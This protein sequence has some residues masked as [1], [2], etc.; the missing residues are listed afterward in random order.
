[1]MIPNGAARINV[2]TPSRRQANRCRTCSRLFIN[3]DLAIVG[4]GLQHRTTKDDCLR[5]LLVLSA[6]EGRHQ[7][8]EAPYCGEE[9]IS[10]VIPPPG[11]DAAEPQ[12]VDVHTAAS[13]RQSVLP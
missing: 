8:L 4:F 6:T 12:E 11:A 10:F 3:Q 9:V 2:G 13:R 1:M 7:W 5:F